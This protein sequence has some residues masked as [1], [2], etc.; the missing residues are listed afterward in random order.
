MF[1]KEVPLDWTSTIGLCEQLGKK[2]PQDLLSRSVQS[3]IEYR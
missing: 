1:L 2:F 3:N